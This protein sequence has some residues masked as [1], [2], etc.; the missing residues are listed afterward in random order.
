MATI[1]KISRS[2]FLELASDFYHS[3]ILDNR[4]KGFEKQLQEDKEQFEEIS[5]FLES[6]DQYLLIDNHDGSKED[7]LLAELEAEGWKS[8]DEVRLGSYTSFHNLGLLVSHK[9]SIV[10]QHGCED[11]EE[12]EA[13][14]LE[15]SKEGSVSAVIERDNE[16]LFEFIF[17]D[18]VG[19]EQEVQIVGISRV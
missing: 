6:I 12:Y 16:I 4:I 3:D 19:E 2:L 14:H 18:L 5:D 13:K 8:L 11:F 7:E 1:Q 17:T 10:E 9:S 15:G